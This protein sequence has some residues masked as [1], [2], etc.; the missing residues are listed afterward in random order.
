MSDF[1]NGSYLISFPKISENYFQN[2]EVYFIEV[3]LEKSSEMIELNRRA[4]MSYFSVT[5][6]ISAGLKTNHGKR[7]TAVCNTFKLTN[8]ESLFCDFSASSGRTWYCYGR[9]LNC[10]VEY[11]NYAH[12]V[13]VFDLTEISEMCG[14]HIDDN[15]EALA[16]S[17]E[18]KNPVKKPGE[19]GKTDKHFKHWI[20]ADYYEAEQSVS[21]INNQRTNRTE[22][23][24]LVSK[25]NG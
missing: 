5:K 1:G 3:F 22:I 4:M 12:A 15:Y 8:D 17:T 19:T 2:K 16:F 13:D 11:E 7:L 18:Y 24:R 25:L 23:N 14:G 10:T 6:T 9:S 20:G 21:V